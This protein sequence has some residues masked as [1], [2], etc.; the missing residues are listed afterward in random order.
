MMSC[1]GRLDL[2][3]ARQL[4]GDNREDCQQAVGR[5]RPT[6][7]DDTYIEL[8][9]LGTFLIFLILKNDI[10]CIFSQVNLTGGRLF[11]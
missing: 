5:G 4:A 10:L 7:K 6:G 1:T 2:G 8:S 9:E 11:K 3:D